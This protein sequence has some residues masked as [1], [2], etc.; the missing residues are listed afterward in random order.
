M[1]SSII[2][3]AAAASFGAVSA[4]SQTLPRSTIATPISAN[5]PEVIAVRAAILQAIAGTAGATT[6]A[7]LEAQI[8]YAIDQ[9]QA[10]CRVV[11]TALRE[12]LSQSGH[13]KMTLAALR[14]VLARVARCE[15]YGTASV[16]GGAQ[17]VL[18]TGPAVG[19]GGGSSSN[20]QLP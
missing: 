16:G 12:T 15:P 20:Y 4:S 6:R 13:N 1:R 9:T 19:I 17:S 7:Q 3:L 5:T 2:V 18:A 11:L 14:D 8:V 10:N